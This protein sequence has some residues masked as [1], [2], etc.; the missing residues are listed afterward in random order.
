MPHLCFSPCSSISPYFAHVLALALLD[1][2]TVSICLGLG[3]KMVP[4]CSCLGLREC[5]GPHASSFLPAVPSHGFLVT[6]NVSLRAPEGWRAL[7]WLGFQES[8]DGMWTAGDLSLT[9][10]MPLGVSPSC[11]PKGCLTSLSFLA[12]DVRCHFSF[13]FQCSLLDELFKVHLSIHYFCSS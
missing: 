10:C 2:M 5:V 1:P 6:P 4:F 7:L 13:K 9:L 11:H 3:S 8:T 12:L